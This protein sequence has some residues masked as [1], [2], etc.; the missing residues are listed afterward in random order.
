METLDRVKNK[1]EQLDIDIEQL[2]DFLVKHLVNI[3]DVITEKNN[4]RNEL[5]FEIDKCN[6]DVS[7]ISE[8]TLISRTTFYSYDHLLKKY[9]RLSHNIDY[10]NDT[11]EKIHKQNEIIQNLK[12][13]NHLMRTRDLQEL[14]LQSE[15]SM[16][17]R[18]IAEKD[19]IIKSLTQQLGFTT[20]K[21]YVSH[22]QQ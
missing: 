7:S 2:P 11:R 20:S 17:K 19:K 8:A 4:R 15:N 16:L 21:K 10:R 13:Q 3:E 9:V 14:K 6:Y 12:E 18:Q 22:V 5:L 1:L